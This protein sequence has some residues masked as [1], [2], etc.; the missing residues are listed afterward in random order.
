[1]LYE[2]ITTAPIHDYRICFDCH[3]SG[4]SMGAY[5]PLAA[6]PAVFH[7]RPSRGVGLTNPAPGKGTFN[8]FYSSIGGESRN[9]GRWGEQESWERLDSVITSYSIHYT[10]LYDL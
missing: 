6:V 5:Y 3:G 7:A 10:K 1:M 4:G 2:V 9:E 8:L